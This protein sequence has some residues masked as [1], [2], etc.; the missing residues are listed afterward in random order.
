MTPLD[1][2]LLVDGGR[3]V[4]TPPQPATP[5]AAGR[6]TAAAARTLCLILGSLGI[7]AGVSLVLAAGFGSDPYSALLV[8]LARHLPVSFAVLNAVAG[9][10]LVA[11][12]AACRVRPG[13]GSIVQPVLVSAAVAAVLPALPAHAQ[14]LPRLLLLV[15]GIAVVAVGVGAYLAAGAGRGPFEAVTEVLARRT[16]Q[17]FGRSYQALLIVCVLAAVLIGGPVG[18]GTVLLAVAAGPA[19]TAVERLLRVWT[20]SSAS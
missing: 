20:G 8:G 16:G 17:P 5:I 2:P 13:P 10:T 18:P 6:S 3:P 1:A 14:L 9:L 15:A 19:V 7:G 12:A 4:T 11:A